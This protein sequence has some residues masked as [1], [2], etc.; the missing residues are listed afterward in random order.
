MTMVTKSINITKE[1]S[2]WMDAQ[3]AQGQY[4][5]DSEL[6]RDLICREQKRQAELDWIRTELEKG[7]ESA[8][9]HG[10]VQK[11][12]EQFLTDIKARARQR[13]DI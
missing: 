10:F 7:E 2:A 6:M 9:Q 1:Q 3:T 5:D 4:D 12:P 8:R 13:G 11:T